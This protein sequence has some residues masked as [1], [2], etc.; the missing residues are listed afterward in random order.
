MFLHLLY[1]L[2]NDC[3][4]TIFSLG[5]KGADDLHPIKIRVQARTPRVDVKQQTPMRIAEKVWNTAP[6]SLERVKFCK[7]EQI[8]KIFEDIE[9]IR[10]D[11]YKKLD[12]GIALTASDVKEIVNYY[13]FSDLREKEAAEAEEKARQEAEANRVTLRMFIDRFRA[14]IKSGKRLTEKGT[15]YASGTINAINQACERLKKFEEKTHTVYD[16]DDIDM[17]F[18]RDYTAYLNGEGYAINTTGKCIKQLKA[19]MATAESEGLHSN[20]KYKDKRFK[21]TRVDVDNI[22]LTKEDLKKIMAVDL[23]KKS[24]GFDLARDIFMVGVWTAQRISDYNNIS[25]EDIQTYSKRIVVDVPDPEH[26]GQTK[27]EIQTREITVLN[28]RQ[29]KTGAKVAIPCSSDLK[30]ILEKYNFDIPH[31]ADQNL[32]YN[33]KDIAKWAGLTEKITIVETKGG[34]PA[35]VQ[36]EKWELVHSHTARRT[37]ATLMYLSGMDIYDIMKITG[38][39]TPQMLKKY[40][41]ADELEVIDKITDKYSYFD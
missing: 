10:V 36:K 17:N 26:P 7:N 4:A 23:S 19:I 5:P 30:K 15:V 41:K 31:L 35:E 8:N 33:I 1:E 25:P 2:N 40:I 22:Y 29:K 38:H 37:G 24:Y 9:N 20:A 13:V 11:I 14:D 16:F 27:A 6:G 21:G 28:I 12:S 39:S 34:R 32:N 3:M 18:Y